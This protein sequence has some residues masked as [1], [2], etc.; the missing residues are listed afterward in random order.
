MDQH[1][2]ERYPRLHLGRLVRIGIPSHRTDTIKV[3]R[4]NLPMDWK[5]TTVVTLTDPSVRGATT[6]R[7][8]CRDGSTVTFH[9]APK[10]K[11]KRTKK[12]KSI[13]TTKRTRRTKKTKKTKRTKK[14]KST[15]RTKRIKT[16]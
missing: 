12:T 1:T 13:K 9:V 4:T 2:E 14:T 8:R 6:V 10:W 11:T 5:K 7:E 3:L 15:K 16:T